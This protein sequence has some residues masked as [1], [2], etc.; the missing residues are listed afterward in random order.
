MEIDIGKERRKSGRET[1]RKEKEMFSVIRIFSFIV[2]PFCF[3][4]FY[5]DEYQLNFFKLMY[6]FCQMFLYP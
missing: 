4:F 5:L 1:E 2:F 3:H 6:I